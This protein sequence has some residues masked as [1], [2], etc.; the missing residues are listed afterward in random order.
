MDPHWNRKDSMLHMD[1]DHLNKQ[2]QDILNEKKVRGE[3]EAYF[4]IF[5]VVYL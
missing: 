1:A 4:V 2:I 5:D 3:S